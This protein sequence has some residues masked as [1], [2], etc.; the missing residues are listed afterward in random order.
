MQAAAQAPDTQKG[1]A[2]LQSALD[3]HA[4][5][6]LGWQVPLV[7]VNPALHPADVVPVQLA[8]HCPSSQT[9]DA[10]HWFE[11]VQTVAAG[12]QAPATHWSPVEQSEVAV[13]GQGPFVPPQVTQAFW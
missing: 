12:S 2:A 11:A 5:A 10:A 6:G 4:L 13:Q 9:S 8:T 7:H 3:L 1:S